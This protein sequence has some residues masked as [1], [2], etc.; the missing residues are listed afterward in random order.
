MQCGDL[1]LAR[2]RARASSNARS[3]IARRL[4]RS[5][6]DPV[7][8]RLGQHQRFG[9]GVDGRHHRIC[10][11]R[12]CVALVLSIGSIHPGG[13]QNART[14]SE[15]NAERPTGDVSPITPWPGWS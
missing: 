10:I 13:A 5:T 7:E 3:A 9:I 11:S 4:G 14:D 12:A 15:R 6:L 1:G 2:R 8:R